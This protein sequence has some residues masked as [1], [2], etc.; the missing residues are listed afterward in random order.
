MNKM[1]YVIIGDLHGTDLNSFENALYRENPDVLICLGDFDQTGTIHQFMGLEKRLLSSGK[2]IIKV[3]G[4]HDH[5]IFYNLPIT[6][7]TLQK[8]GKT[9]HE[10]YL[11]LMADPIAKEYIE[12]LVN[13]GF[14]GCTKNRVRIFLDKEKFGEEYPTIIVHGGLDGNLRSYPG[15]PERIADLWYRLECEEDKLNPNRLKNEK[16]YRKNFDAMNEKGY[17]VMIRGHDHEPAY[18]YNDP[19][20]GIGFHRPKNDGDS[21]CLFGHRQHTINPGALFDGWFAI[22]DTNVLGYNVPILTYRKL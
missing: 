21:Y 20:K 17:K 7:G 8:Q 22:I 11:K 18:V 1:K 13:S 6:S 9:S 12:N 2:A 4:N 14:S 3:P 5:A 19:S 10:L 16:D 15:C